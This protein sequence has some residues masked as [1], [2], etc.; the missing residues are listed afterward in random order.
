M[1]KRG[2]GFEAAPSSDEWYTPAWLMSEVALRFDLDPCAHPSSPVRRFVA[3]QYVKAGVDG[4]S[5]PWFG[6]V[7]LN[8]PYSNIEV[9]VGQ[10]LKHIHAGGTAVTLT[11]CRTERP[12]AQNLLGNATEVLFLGKNPK[13]GKRRVHFIAG[14]GKKASSPGGPSMLCAFGEGEAVALH[15]MARRGHG[16]VLHSWKPPE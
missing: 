2:F 7:W 14:A 11:Y 10:L 12:W 8:P 5:A 13:D 1:N 16:V 3:N 15:E 6:R 9:W 4:L